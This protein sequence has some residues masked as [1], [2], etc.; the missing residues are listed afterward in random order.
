MI[1]SY[2]KSCLN[3]AEIVCCVCLGPITAAGRTCMSVC[4]CLCVCLC[5]CMCIYVCFCVCLC[6]C[7]FV[8][9]R[10]CVYYRLNSGSVGFIPTWHVGVWIFS[11]CYVVLRRPRPSDEPI[12]RQRVRNPRNGVSLVSL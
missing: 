3:I 1:K 8:C 5:V 7:V 6:V 2:L 10:V 11:F 12:P 4:V 9:V